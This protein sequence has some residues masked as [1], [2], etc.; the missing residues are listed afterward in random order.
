MQCKESMR[1][2][3]EGILKKLKIHCSGLLYGIPLSGTTNLKIAAHFGLSP[4]IW[5]A[6]ISIILKL[7][8]LALHFLLNENI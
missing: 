3:L 1:L 6:L 2:R 8:P 4:D 5:N 7:K